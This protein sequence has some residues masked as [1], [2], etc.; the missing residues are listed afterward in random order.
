MN[1]YHIQRGEIRTTVTL[2]STICE[3]LALKL[4]IAPDARESHKAVRGWLQSAS[5]QDSDSN[6]NNLS[7]WLKRKAILHIADDG[8][9][10]KHHQWKDEI[11]RSWDAELTQRVADVDSG[12][13][14]MIS[15]DEVFKNIREQLS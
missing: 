13:V 3:L 12:K 6:T 7:Q 1:R 14:K 9:L 8:L 4:G 2:D 10:T 11:D 5:E 15:K